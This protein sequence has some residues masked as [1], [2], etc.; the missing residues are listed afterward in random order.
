MACSRAGYP[1]RS[2]CTWA[3]LTQAGSRVYQEKPRIAVF[4]ISE[5]KM[6]NIGGGRPHWREN[7]RW[8]EPWQKGI[9]W[10][11]CKEKE[12]TC[13][14]WHPLWWPGVWG[15]VPG[16][17]WAEQWLGA[18]TRSGRGRG[19][20]RSEWRVQSETKAGMEGWIPIKAHAP[21]AWGQDFS[22]EPEGPPSSCFLSFLGA[23]E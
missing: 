17:S 5:S 1:A 14:R 15:L 19:C 9:L 10:A 4:S 8:I 18:G 21:G 20:G 22:E 6:R 11:A 13:F 3:W 12:G 2:C 16:R 7:K 23:E